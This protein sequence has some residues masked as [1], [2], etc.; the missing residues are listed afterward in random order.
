MKEKFKSLKLFAILAIF[1]LVTILTS[2]VKKP[3]AINDVHDTDSIEQEYIPSV[4]EVLQ[5][6]EEM[7]FYRYCDSVYL[8]MPTQIV[9]QI[10]VTKGTQIPIQDIVNT[11]ITNK[12]FYDKIIKHAMDVQK[13]Y[14]P[15]SMPKPSIPEPKNDSLKS[16]FQFILKLSLLYYS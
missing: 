6:R 16:S 14:L 1:M 13:Q 10:L 15:D 4:K 7:R 11:Y 3:Q 5:E 2:C 12:E 9:T 8:D